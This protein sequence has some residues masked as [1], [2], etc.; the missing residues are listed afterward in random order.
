MPSI[1]QARVRGRQEVRKRRAAIGSA[2]I[3]A[4]AIGAL[5]VGAL[6]IGAIAIGRL[7]VG[8]LA[9]GSGRIARL[10]IDDL[11]VRRL[12]ILE[13]PQTRPIDGR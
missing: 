7:A 2:G 6:A 10:E 9:L 3:G 8:R 1:D 4:V 13:A 5:A 12:S 11:T